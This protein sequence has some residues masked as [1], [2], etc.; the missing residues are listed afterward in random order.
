M[1]HVALAEFSVPTHH[2]SLFRVPWRLTICLPIGL[3]FPRF[4]P[5]YWFIVL[6]LH[7]AE[8][9]LAGR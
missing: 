2:L 3:S 7:I 9:L 4:Q 5:T 1:R 6:V 8:K